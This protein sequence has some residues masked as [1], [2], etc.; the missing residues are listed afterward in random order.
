VPLPVFYG[1]AA[2]VAVVGGCGVS[3]W[4]ERAIAAGEDEVVADAFTVAGL[5]LIV[6]ASWWAMGHPLR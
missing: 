6:V 3:L 2:I 1:V 5:V 4:A